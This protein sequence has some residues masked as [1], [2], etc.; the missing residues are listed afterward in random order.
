VLLSA[1]AGPQR[2]AAAPEPRAP[3]LSVAV[4]AGETACQAGG[5]LGI[6]VDALLAA[7]QL[8]QRPELPLTK[9]SLLLPQGAVLQHQI[10]AGQTLG[11]VAAWY[12]HSVREL[13]RV[14][15]LADPDRIEAGERL[16]IPAGART[17]CPPAAVV[18]RESVLPAVA[19][20]PRTRPAS[21]LAPAVA[22]GPSPDLIARAEDLLA[23]ARSRYDAADFRA[24]LAFARGA[25]DLLVV[26]PDHPAS[27]DLRARAAWLEGLALAGLDERDAAARSLREAIA[28]QPALRNDPRLSPRILALLEGEEARSARG[29]VASEGPP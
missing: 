16:R 1:C 8:R 14:N 18:A 28:L 3:G 27:V 7:N 19:A 23:R 10:R 11:A 13:A 20:A 2:K 12:G 17:G 24:V 4:V 9:S 29:R 25:S 26:R 5:R 21:S 15:Q 6:S 22:P